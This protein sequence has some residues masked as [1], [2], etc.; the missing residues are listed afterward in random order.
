MMRSATALLSVCVFWVL[1]IGAGAK[2]YQVMQNPD[3]TYKVVDPNPPSLLSRFFQTARLVDP[4][5]PRP[6]SSH[7]PVGFGPA[8]TQRQME[9]GSSPAGVVADSIANTINQVP[10]VNSVS[11]PFTQTINLGTQQSTQ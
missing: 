3:G 10:I 2:V 5:L 4:T 9:I 7:K 8:I 1:P 11:Q 6:S